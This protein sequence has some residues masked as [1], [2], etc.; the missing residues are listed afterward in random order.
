MVLSEIDHLTEEMRNCVD[1]CF[2]VV[3][4]CEACTDGYEQFDHEHCQVCADVLRESAQSC[5]GMALA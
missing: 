3:N 5:R 4:A 1:N 2:E